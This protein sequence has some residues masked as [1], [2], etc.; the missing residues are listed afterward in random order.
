MAATMKAIMNA[1]ENNQSSATTRERRL[2]QLK[3]VV[4]GNLKKAFPN[5]KEVTDNLEA[6]FDLFAKKAPFVPDDKTRDLGSSF[7]NEASRDV[8]SCN[9]LNSK[10][11]Y[12]HA[13]YHLQQAVEKSVKGYVLLEGYFNVTELREIATHR[14][15]L[16]MM[17][18]TLE[19][20]GI[21][22]LAEISKDTTLKNKIEA[23]EATMSS[24]EKR[25]EIAEISQKEI[26]GL[27]SQIEEYR[28]MGCLLESSF[29]DGLT[30]I[31]FGLTPTSLFQSVSAMVALL[32]LAIITFP[33]EAYTRYPDPDGKMSPDNYEKKLGIVCEAPRM[34]RL[35]EKEIRN[36][37]KLYERKAPNMNSLKR[38]TESKS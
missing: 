24:E 11:V 36:L 10:K 28:K 9:L 20:T 3:P 22:G 6:I 35:L 23:A 37:Q 21:K 12:P 26:K 25:I 19:R 38:T 32:I 29:S 4:V 1:R 31:G 18:A 5:N 8:K 15:P 34:V 2:A 30:G 13:V 16:V 17:K 33:H 14:S 7:L 27:C